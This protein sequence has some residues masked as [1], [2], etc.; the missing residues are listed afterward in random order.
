MKDANKLRVFERKIIRRIYGTIE[1][2]GI[3]RL[4]TN[5]EIDDILQ[6]ED[7]VRFIKAQRLRWIGH[8]ERMKENR[9]PKRIY[10]ASM[11][12]RRKQGR[13][14][15]RWKDEVEKDIRNMGIRGWKDKTR[16]RKEWKQVVKQPKAH[17]EL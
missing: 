5:L 1:E 13:P 14:R 6:K 16:D 10:K 17:P 9:V 3:W 4:R 15:S 7:I 12:G 2:N 8:V 11:T